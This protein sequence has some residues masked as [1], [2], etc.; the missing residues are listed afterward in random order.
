MDRIRKWS[1]RVSIPV[2]FIICGLS[3]L[4]AAILLTN[5]TVW[6][7]KKNMNEIEA[8]YIMQLDANTV[9]AN[10]DTYLWGVIDNTDDE[11]ETTSLESSVVA[12]GGDTS[13]NEQAEEHTITAYRSGSLLGIKPIEDGEPP[14]YVVSVE[15]G[16]LFRQE[17]QLPE[18]A[19]KEYDFYVGLDGIAAVLWYSLCLCLAALIFYIWKIKRP[20]DVLNQSVRKISANDLNFRIEYDGED[21]F[22]RL[23]HAFE[24]M[25]Q[26][27]EQNNKKMWNSMEERKRLNAAF[28]HDLR[29]P[30]TVMRGHTDMLLSMITQDTD[31]G[32]EMASSIRAIS[33]QITRLGTFADT[34]G[35][36]Q[37]LEDYEP[38]LEHMSSTALTEMVSQAAAALFPEGQVEIRSELTE[39]EF[40]LDK[41]AL[42]QICENIL[43]NAVRYVK[44][45]LTI[46][47]RQEREYVLITVEDDGAGFTKKDLANASSAYYRGEKTQ[48]DSASH[49]GLGLY[50]SSILAEKLGGGLQLSNGTGG[51]AKIQIKI[52][53]V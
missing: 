12:I 5:A 34:M 52:R 27:L 45:M 10:G 1:R 44:E 16:K 18:E 25:R 15:N 43:S 13:S 9:P 46:S 50:I 22:G 7:S 28:A 40:F 48:A 51:G 47:L 42:A 14:A 37:R 3:C 30:L 35:S 20:F 53:C 26:E 2:A 4:L 23:C 11:E 39:Q 41:E 36:L 19:R 49:F 24:I 29:T 8:E 33:N 6:F 32:G 31:S 17:I 21:E 38:C